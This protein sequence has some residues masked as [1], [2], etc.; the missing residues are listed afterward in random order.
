MRYQD[1]QPA[2]HSRRADARAMP[3]SGR[4]H[5]G[6]R[7]P[8]R[9]GPGAQCQF[10]LSS[11]L[12]NWVTRFGSLYLS[13]STSCAARRCTPAFPD[14]LG[15]LQRPM[16]LYSL[17]GSP[18]SGRKLFLTI[19]SRRGATSKRPPLTAVTSSGSSTMPP[20]PLQVLC[21]AY[22]MRPRLVPSTRHRATGPRLRGVSD[23]GRGRASL[24]GGENGRLP[25]HRL[26]ESRVQ[27]LLR[28]DRLR[29]RLR[30]L[31]LS[32]ALVQRLDS[33]HTLDARP[34]HRTT[35]QNAAAPP[36]LRPFCVPLGFCCLSLAS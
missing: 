25:L 23:R 27:P 19:P 6:S 29:A 15:R 14:R 22:A 21:A 36:P 11:A 26:E 8:W 4:H 1:T 34:E 28:Q 24:R 13:A 2:D 17:T 12:P 9:G 16:V 18:P 32:A 35:P 7:L 3:R 20:F 30:F 33:R 10:G 31:A 5:A